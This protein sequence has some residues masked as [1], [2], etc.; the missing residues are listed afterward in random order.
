MSS[1]LDDHLEAVRVGFKKKT[2]ENVGNTLAS[3][4]IGAA[5]GYWAF[6]TLPHTVLIFFLVF[7]I[8]AVGNRITDELFRLQAQ[9]KATEIQNR[10]AR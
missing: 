2:R 7:V 4:C 10:T 9:Q 3:A 8:S 5:L 6:G 1:E